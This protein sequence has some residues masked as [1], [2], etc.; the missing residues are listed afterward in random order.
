MTHWMRRSRGGASIALLLTLAG[1]EAPT[2]SR[3]GFAFDPTTLSNGQLY[4]WTSGSRVTVW[5]E[6]GG[7]NAALDLG[8][9]TRAA[10]VE[11]NTIP[12]FAEFELVV[13]NGINDANI[14]VYDRATPSPVLPGTCDFQPMNSGGYT[15][16]C[17]VAGRAER[18]ALSAGGAS[19]VSVV[20]RVD[21]G[22]LTSQTSLDALMAHELG[23]AIGIGG[24]SDDVNDVMFG[25]PGFS[26]PSNRDSRT[27]QYL[28]GQR[29]DITL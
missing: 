18:L 28:L 22:R 20:I 9:A 17:P 13:A 11:W 26:R 15:Y 29:P 24:H 8:R 16:F 25:L 5:V 14:V 19:R 4:R 27:L 2:A 21:A 6:G 1:C 23:H 10:M 7:G 12:V 3:P